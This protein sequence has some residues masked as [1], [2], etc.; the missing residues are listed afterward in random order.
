MIFGYILK[1]FEAQ[2]AFK[3]R[4][5]AS[6]KILSGVAKVDILKVTSTHVLYIFEKCFFVP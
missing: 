5:K 1:I 4:D 2:K 3:Y 6:S